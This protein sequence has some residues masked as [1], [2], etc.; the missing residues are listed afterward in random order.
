VSLD[1]IQAEFGQEI[2]QKLLN[3]S[4]KHISQKLLIIKDNTIIT[5]SK[6]KFLCDG[7]ASDLFLV[8]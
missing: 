3:Y 7:I 8:N 4:E 1:R 6:G 2:Y 5:T